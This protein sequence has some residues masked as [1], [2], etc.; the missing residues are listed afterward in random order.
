[1]QLFLTCLIYNNIAIVNTS[2]NN[3]KNNNKNISY[4]TRFLNQ[5]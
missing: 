2:A 5:V 4:F 3:N 1:M